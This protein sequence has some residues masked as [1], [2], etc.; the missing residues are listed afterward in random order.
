VGRPEGEK[1]LGRPRRKLEDAKMDHEDIGYKGM[2][3][4][5]LACYWDKW[6]DIVKTEMNIWGP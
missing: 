1:P 2:D 6:R 5:D 3:W 4:I